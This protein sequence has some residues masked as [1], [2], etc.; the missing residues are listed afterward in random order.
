MARI[1][2]ISCPG[3]LHDFQ[4]VVPDR[5]LGANCQAEF[6]CLIIFSR[7]WTKLPSS[8]AGADQFNNNLVAIYGDPTCPRET[9]KKEGDAPRPA[10]LRPDVS[11]ALWEPEGP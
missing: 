5:D 9:S 11:M 2:P 10:T 7:L 1:I 4:P 6:G 8:F 3:S